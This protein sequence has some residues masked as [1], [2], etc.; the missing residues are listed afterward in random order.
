MLCSFSLACPAGG[1]ATSVAHVRMA[2]APTLSR[3]HRGHEEPRQTGRLLEVVQL[4]VDQSHA[5]ADAQVADLLVVE[6]ADAAV[7]EP[8]RDA[9]DL[10]FAAR[11]L[12]DGIAGDPAGDCAAD[13]RQRAA[14]AAAELVAD[15]AADD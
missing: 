12:L 8:D 7:V 4:A 1:R 13:R 6:V 15:D 10:V 9:E 3:R 14:A 2:A 11:P 5:V